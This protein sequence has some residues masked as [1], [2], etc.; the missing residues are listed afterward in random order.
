MAAIIKGWENLGL[1]TEM[2]VA[3]FPGK[4]RHWQNW[5]FIILL[6][7][8]KVHWLQS[9]PLASCLYMEVLSKFECFQGMQFR[10]FHIPEELWAICGLHKNR[11]LNL[12]FYLLQ[13]GITLGFPEIL[14]GKGFSGCPRLQQIHQPRIGWIHKARVQ[15]SSLS[16]SP[17]KT[18]L[19]VRIMDM[20]AV[21]AIYSQFSIL[22]L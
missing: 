8:K 15:I 3:P 4:S 5:Y 16:K 17:V 11:F 9:S 13:S 18:V 10:Y 12:L 14:W 22:W 19:L 21:K 1:G 2:L 6:A 20:S 7:L